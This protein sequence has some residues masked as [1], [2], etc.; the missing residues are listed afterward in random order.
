[1]KKIIIII[2]CCVLL[3]SCT[4]IS[5]LLLIN[6]GNIKSDT[7]VDEYIYYQTPP[8]YHPLSHSII[9]TVHINQSK[10]PFN[11]ILDTGALTVISKKIAKELNIK[12][13]LTIKANDVDGN[14]KDQSLVKLQS[15]KIKDIEV[16]DIAAGIFDLSMFDNYDLDIDGIV[17]SNALRFFKVTLDYEKNS[18]YFSNKKGFSEKQKNAYQL[19]FE[20][21]ITNGFAPKLPCVINNNLTLDAYI[22]TGFWGYALL[23]YNYIDKLDIEKNHLITSIGTMSGGMFKNKDSKS[24]LS[25]LKSIKFNAGT[26]SISLTKPVV[27]FNSRRN[28]MMK[29]RLYLGKRFLMNY[30]VT[31][32]YPNNFLTLQPKNQSSSKEIPRELF[33]FGV[34]IQ[35]NEKRELKIIGLWKGSSADNVGLKT[36]DS[37]VEID[38]I[39]IKH[40]SVSEVFQKL[41]D[42]DVK[43]LNLKI[44]RGTQI[45]SFNLEKQMLL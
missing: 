7:T 38:D 23:P 41:N 12:N 2:L 11:F 24:A 19:K 39:N 21:D 5:A 35:P 18:I 1:M 13:E 8:A 10:K 42:T 37:L 36:N 43:K 40:L 20:Q 34:K 44:K 26:K 9:L 3:S 25:K 32:D 27:N 22:D 6:S 4:E 14:T 15:L 28:P 16:K 29:N 33:S 45:L 30:L 31:I 17:G